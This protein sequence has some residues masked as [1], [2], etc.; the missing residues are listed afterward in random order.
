MSDPDLAAS[1]YP[2]HTELFRLSNIQAI[3]QGVT[4]SWGV[5]VLEDEVAQMIRM[6]YG[7]RSD[8]SFLERRAV[9]TGDLSGIWEVVDSINRDVANRL[10]KLNSVYSNLD[11]Y[12]RYARVFLGDEQPD[13]SVIPHPA[14]TVCHRKQNVERLDGSNILGD[15]GSFFD[16]Y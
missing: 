16:D 5:D 1:A 10:G 11:D 14:Y 13:N 2:V 8:A 3:Q 12:E 7:L 6:V 4:A 15:D 9:E